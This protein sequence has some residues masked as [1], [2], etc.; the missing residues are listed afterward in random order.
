M[1]PLFEF[2]GTKFDIF[3]GAQTSIYCA[4]AEELDDKNKSGKYFADCGQAT[5][6]FLTDEM[7]E[8]LWK[9]S[10]ELTGSS[11]P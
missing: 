8:K 7:A 11:L 4:V 2:H 9:T 3:S 1:K 10:E 6:T 5:T